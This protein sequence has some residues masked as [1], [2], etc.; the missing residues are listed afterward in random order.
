MTAERGVC[1]SF[2]RT[3]NRD[4]LPHPLSFL[5]WQQFVVLILGLAFCATLLVVAFRRR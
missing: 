4:A 5:N 2:N 1:G 3:F